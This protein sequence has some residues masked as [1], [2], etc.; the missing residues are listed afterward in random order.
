MIAAG[1]L[2][3]GVAFDDGAAGHYIDGQLKH[4][5]SSRPNAKGYR[6]ERDG[7]QARE[8]VL[9][10]DYLAARIQHMPDML[11]KLY[12]LPEV[13]AAA[14]R[15]ERAGNRHASGHRAGEAIVVDWVR[16]HFGELLGERDGSR[17]QQSSGKL[18]DRHA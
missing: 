7:D 3:A 15:A 14:R 16:K 18:L 10:T 17:L 8:T 11:V 12:E 1:E 13:E 5:V 2:P 9:E 4:V 6:V